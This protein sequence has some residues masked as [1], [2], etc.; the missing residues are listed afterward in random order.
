MTVVQVFIFLTSSQH[1]CYV[2]FY[3]QINKYFT[4]VYIH[5]RVTLILQC[6]E[7]VAGART[8]ARC[9]AVYCRKRKSTFINDPVTS[10]SHPY[11]VLLPVLPPNP[12]AP[13][14]ST[15]DPLATKDWARRA[16]NVDIIFEENIY[17]WKYLIQSLF[18]DKQRTCLFK[19]VTVSL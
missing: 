11:Y 4:L 16:E 7:K 6:I 19:Q 5:T 2:F 18:W 12:L 13:V 9:L 17:L 8:T 14:T 15:G 10:P 1:H 3:N